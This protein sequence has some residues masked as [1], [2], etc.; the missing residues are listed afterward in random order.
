MSYHVVGNIAH[1][2]TDHQDHVFDAPCHPSSHPDFN[3]TPCTPK[4]GK[5]YQPKSSLDQW[6]EEYRAMFAAYISGERYHDEA[7][8]SAFDKFISGQIDKSYS[9]ALDDVLS[10]MPHDA[11]MRWRNRVEG[12]RK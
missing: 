6:K 2:R 12:L 3:P 1:C 7:F 10:I 8:F 4:C 11:P 9:K 5:W